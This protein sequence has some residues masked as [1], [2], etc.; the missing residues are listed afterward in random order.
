MSCLGPLVG[1]CGPGSGPSGPR[2]CINGSISPT[3]PGESRRLWPR[4]I[5]KRWPLPHILPTA[6]A[7][8]GKLVARRSPAPLI[9]HIYAPPGRPVPT[10]S[11]PVAGPC[12][13]TTCPNSGAG[14]L[15]A[16]ALGGVPRWRWEWLRRR[17]RPPHR[18][19][20]VHEGWSAIMAK[21]GSIASRGRVG[22]PGDPA[23]G[24]PPV[25]PAPPVAP[26][27][28]PPRKSAY[29]KPDRPQV[30]PRR[31]GRPQS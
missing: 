22:R 31:P 12:F 9:S 23:S 15:P 7:L 16:K 28:V 30:K 6:E 26:K 20:C 27:P 5:W 18:H 29:R 13:G 8:P 19:Q 17:W 10:P 25:A 21:L 14:A 3:A 2:F 11:S 4:Q 24:S 1:P